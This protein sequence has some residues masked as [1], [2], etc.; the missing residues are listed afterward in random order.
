MNSEKSETVRI[1]QIITLQGKLA[2]A[3]QDK[4]CLGVKVTA[5]LSGVEMDERNTVADFTR[6]TEPIFELSVGDI[7][8]VSVPGSHEPLDSR[9][10]I[11]KPSTAELYALADNKTP[12]RIA[13]FVEVTGRVGNS[14]MKVHEY[15]ASVAQ[16]LSPTDIESLEQEEMSGLSQPWEIVRHQE[17][18]CTNQ[19]N[20]WLL[21]FWSGNLTRL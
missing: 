12:L 5:R 14:N 13:S 7:V 11:K 17:E 9:T 4:R 18:R 2:R 1:G 3:L 16:T 8:T 20:Y 10:E 21:L 19:D 15:F 6:T